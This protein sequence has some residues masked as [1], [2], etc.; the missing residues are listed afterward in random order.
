MPTI[1]LRMYWEEDVARWE[2]L[3]AAGRIG[4]SQK[5]YLEAWRVLKRNHPRMVAM[6]VSGGS[7]AVWKED[8]HAVE[9]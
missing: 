8:R 9:S 1:S 6:S 2:R 5:R 3:E 4:P 7:Y